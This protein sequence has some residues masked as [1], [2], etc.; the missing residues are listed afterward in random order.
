MDGSNIDFSFQDRLGLKKMDKA[1][2]LVFLSIDGDHLRFS[3]I[4]FIDN[5]IKPYLN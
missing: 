5:I 1:G 2:K 4:W 3:D